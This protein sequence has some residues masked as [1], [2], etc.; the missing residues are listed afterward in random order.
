VLWICIPFL[1]IIQSSTL[2]AVLQQQD[3]PGGRTNQGVPRHSLETVEHSLSLFTKVACMADNNW[4]D[5]STVEKARDA[6]LL[7]KK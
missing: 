2:F 5:C 7:L 1:F 4:M 3:L 6:G